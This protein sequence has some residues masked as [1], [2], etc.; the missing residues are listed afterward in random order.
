MRPLFYPLDRNADLQS[1]TPNDP[2]DFTD[3]S[4]WGSVD[5]DERQN[6]VVQLS[7]NEYVALANS[8]DV[9]RDIAYG[10]NSIEIWFTWVRS[11]ISL[12]ICQSIADCINDP[13]SPARQAVL[14]IANANSQNAIR[15]YA[16]SLNTVDLVGDS[17]PSC[18]A[19]ILFG[20]CLQLVEY[21]HRINLDVLEIFEVVTNPYEA[22]ASTV[23]NASGVDETNGDV[24]LQWLSFVQNSIAENYASQ[25]TDSYLESRACEIFCIAR[26]LDCAI[27]PTILFN[28][29]RDRLN[30]T[31][32]INSLINEAFVYLISGIWLGDEIA[33][34]MFFSQ[35]A[36]R[37]LWGEI[38]GERAYNDID[39]RITLYSND[40][41]PDWA[42]LCAVCT[43][44][45]TFTFAD[46]DEGWTIVKGRI[47]PDYI[48]GEN[49]VFPTDTEMDI[50]ISI[51]F[52]ASDITS[53][54]IET[55][56]TGSRP[57]PSTN[58]LILFNDIGSVQQWNITDYFSDQIREWTGTMNT[59]YL[60][61]RT[62]AS[63]FIVIR[64]IKITVTGTGDNPFI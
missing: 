1:D 27:T 37:S 47:E 17:N 50:D 21:L 40:P 12:N 57:V 59:D 60:R 49:T 46:S 44:S 39:F 41:N 42:L 34:F 8:I 36:L 33:D 10:D 58:N 19:D 24:F 4:E 52:S 54:S 18:D 30:A 28:L 61:V 3:L 14:D 16:Q 7:L 55:Y 62:L 48:L 35:L 31:V 45:H 29:W 26:Q 43:W 63:E 38:V 32:N 64:L 51:S 6:I 53:V 15:E 2:I 20:Q 5:P 11:I 13:Q 22:V 23:G 9:G 56:R 25:V